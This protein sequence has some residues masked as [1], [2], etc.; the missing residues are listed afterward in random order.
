MGIT[1]LIDKIKINHK[2][3]AAWKSARV[4]LC[5]M[6]LNDCNLYCKEADGD[7]K[8][9][10]LTHSKP[11]RGKLI[12]QTPYAKRQYWE[13]ETAHTDKNPLATWK[14][15]ETAKRLHKEQWQ[16]QAQVLFEQ[17]LAKNGIVDVD[18]GDE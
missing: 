12:W 5:E 8:A 10:A 18:G 7:L 11:K 6:V 2:V 15:C 3:N 17:E 14:W 4:K 16:R 9:S 1:F 13:I